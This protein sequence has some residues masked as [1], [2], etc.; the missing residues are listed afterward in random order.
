MNALIKYRRIRLLLPIVVVGLIAAWIYW[1]QP[2]RADLA[3]FAPSDC[4]AFVEADNAS[5]L[6][7]GLE[8]SQGW[9]TLAGPIGARSNALAN[10]WLVRVA[11]WFGI[12]NA[13][14]ILLARSQFGIVITGAEAAET[15]PTLTIR[16]LATLIIETHSSPRR[17]RPA[18]EGHF[19]EFARRI[20][21][22]PQFTRKQIDG[23][24]ITE[25]SSSDG[26]RHI[27]MGFLDSAVIIGNDETSVLSCME[28]K[29]GKRAALAGDKFFGDFRGTVNIPD[30]SLFGFVSRSGVKSIL[31]AY[32]LYKAASSDAVNASRLLSD[33]AGNLVNGLGCRSQFVEGMV[34]DRCFLALT[35][36][37]ADKLRPTMVA[38]D[39]LEIGA[40]PFVPQ[41]A[42]S[43]SIYH[44]RDV[45]G[46]WNDLNAVVSSHTD[47]IGALAARPLLRS[48]LKPYGIDD[49][50]GFVHAI[51]A[52]IETVR[53]E[54]NSPSVLV[55]EALDRQSLRKLA[56]RRLGP[57]PRAE[58]VGELE[59]LLS[60]SDNWGASFAENHLLIGPA[61]SVRRCL[62]VQSQSITSIE[63]FRRSER[64]VDVSLPLTAITFKSDRQTAISFVELFSEHERPSFS[65]NANAVDQAARS[66][67]YAVNVT[68]LKDN[69][70]EWTS[71]STFGLPGSLVI[72]L[73]PER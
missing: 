58:T 33:T 3:T 19:E 39:R 18:L 34:E 6:L 44:L 27:V 45:D 55:T 2:H 17:V 28:T 50:D 8:E 62:Q 63:G 47:V 67:P 49:P 56:A 20:Y 41:D 13:D 37:V 53:L 65:T 1:S 60:N 29:R 54:E 71:R 23:A 11:R 30:S 24:E 57:E 46:F 10:R 32:A 43:V 72:A 26:V 70:F 38:Q 61:E 52:R 48:L 9:R 59:L 73:A 4:L 14:A 64:L 12:G 21:G 7:A 16:P 25:W 36:G 42:Y 68:M 15:G 31:Q 22:Q 35:E 69:G 5:E 40:L 51:G 66:L